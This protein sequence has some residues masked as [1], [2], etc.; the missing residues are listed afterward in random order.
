LNQPEADFED[1]QEHFVGNFD[2]ACLMANDGKVHVIASSEKSKTEKVMDDNRAS[3]TTLRVGMA[4]GDQGPFIFLITGKKVERE[5]MKDLC[6]YFKCPPGSIVLPSPNAFMTNDVFLQ[7]APYLAAGIRAM[8][9]VCDHSD[10]WVAI[11]CDGFGSHVNVPLAQDIFSEHKIMV[12]KEEGDTSHVN[13]AY[14]QFV[15]KKDKAIMRDSLEIVRRVL[16]SE[17]IDQW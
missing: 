8:P 12:I 14:D 2:E 16:I 1:V 13:Q 3:I 11:S 7:L 9:V 10:W 5:K 6:K 17:R 15:A 4:S